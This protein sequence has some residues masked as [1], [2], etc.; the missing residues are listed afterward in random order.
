MKER[1]LPYSLPT[2]PVPV[3]LHL[4]CSIGAHGLLHASILAYT[5]SYSRLHEIVI[6]A[7]DVA[8]LPSSTQTRVRTHCDHEPVAMFMRCGPSSIRHAS[9]PLPGMSCALIAAEVSCSTNAFGFAAGR[10]RR[11]SSGTDHPSQ[12][13]NGC[14]LGFEP[15]VK[16]ANRNGVGSTRGNLPITMSAIN[17]PAPGPMPKP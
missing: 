15:S 17:R 13:A 11:V 5:L 7:I 8:R 14:G 4:L 16:R 2:G 9:T 3:M 1:T 6:R 10:P 12:L